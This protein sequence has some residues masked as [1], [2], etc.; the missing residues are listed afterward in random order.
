MVEA[1]KNL[2]IDKIFIP[3]EDY[4]ERRIIDVLGSIG[5]VRYK[6]PLQHKMTEEEKAK[7]GGSE[8]WVGVEWDDPARGKHNGCV[9]GFQYFTCA[10]NPNSTS[11]T[12][13]RL[14]K[15]DFG[16]NFYNGL[17]QKYFKNSAASGFNSSKQED[18]IANLPQ[19]RETHE[20][21]QCNSLRELMEKMGLGEKK[22]GA[23]DIEKELL[24]R[25][26]GRSPVLVEYDKD[27]YVP[28][29]RKTMRRV[30]FIG[31]DRIWSKINNLKEILELS[32]Q[33]QKISDLGPPGLLGALVPNLRLLS[34][35]NNLIFDWNQVYMIGKELP[36]LEEL[37]LSH[38][39]LRKPEDVLQK[40]SIIVNSIGEQIEESPV[41]IFPKLKTLILIKMDL[42]WRD[43]SNILPAFSGTL[44]N[45]ILSKNRL[46]DQE[47]IR[48]PKDGKFLNN[49]KTLN[50]ENN[51]INSFQGLMNFS[52]LGVERLV[53]NSN[54]LSSIGVMDGFKEV[55][56]ISFE[57]NL[58]VDCKILN[59]L[60][61]FPK[62][63]T[64]R[65]KKNP[66]SDKFG[67]RYVR[68]RAV[69]EIPTLKTI[70]G[71]DL[72]KYERK[73]CEI[74]YLRKTFEDYFK[75]VNRPDY[76]YD[77]DHFM[78]FAIENHP[79]IPQLIKIYG[80]PYEIAPKEEI[81]NEEKINLKSA[82]LSF[83]ITSLAGPLLGRAPLNK[84]FPSST[85]VSTLKNLFAK[86][87][88]IPAD[89]QLIYYKNDPHEPMEL[90]D[91]DYKMLL[92][93][94]L[95]DG[96]ELIVDDSQNNK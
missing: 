72:K 20:Y 16:T 28:S 59:E 5:T 77:F 18:D 65:I 78:N 27:G 9:A 14:E 44:E 43:V 41:N 8:A 32:L 90:L 26:F 58:S 40:K 93:Y 61:Q 2:S 23:K 35:E 4:I 34:L 6:G 11:G 38:N 52:H 84:K 83:K 7:F 67:A 36:L 73:D 19:K 87:I 48:I 85:T 80:N 76:D 96:A 1:T 37:S 66:V 53:L 45:L 94:N 68:Q 64:L 15:A 50:V 86:L 42:T 47:N 70:N 39:K 89:S 82:S 22:E 29:S 71:S 3:E 30:E 75:M 51:D 91:E 10:T 95:K 33:A 81:K 25:P 21:L 57:E 31:F 46:Y 88:G 92:Y 79:R 49:L 74:F 56:N 55:Q 13:V 63:H 54:L 24:I 12:L 69:A 17:M 60:A 62:L